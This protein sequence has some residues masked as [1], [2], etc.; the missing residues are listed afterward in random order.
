MWKLLF[1]QYESQCPYVP[2]NATFRMAHTKIF[3]QVLI[4]S[5]RGIVMLIAKM[6]VATKI[7]LPGWAR[8]SDQ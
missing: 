2:E 8:K 1:K 5:S 6:P 4:V 7:V 3:A